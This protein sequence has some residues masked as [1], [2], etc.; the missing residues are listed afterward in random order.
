MGVDQPI[1]QGVGGCGHGL[2][3]RALWSCSSSCWGD[4]AVAGR[5][6]GIA[7]QPVF[8]AAAYS[9]PFCGCILADV[10]WPVE[11]SLRTASMVVP[12]GC[13]LFGHLMRPAHTHGVTHQV[14]LAAQPSQPARRQLTRQTRVAVPVPGTVRTG[15]LGHPLPTGYGVTPSTWTRRVA[16]SIANSTYSRCR[17]TVSTVKKS[18]ARTP[19]AWARRNCRQLSAARAAGSPGVAAPRPCGATPAARRPWSP[20]FSPAA[21]ATAASDRS[22]DRAVEEPCADHRGPATPVAKLQ[23]STHDGLSGTHTMRMGK[24]A[25]RPHPQAGRERTRTSEPVTEFLARTGSGRMRRGRRLLS[26]RLSASSLRP[27]EASA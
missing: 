4:R 19:W 18:T 9:R 11:S 15:L 17:K 24:T 13:Q 27:S 3:A 2:P 5:G 25:G 10:A 14:D 8:R 1:D 20:S 16:T 6:V 21:R 12:F 23:L 7:V 22:A 26:P